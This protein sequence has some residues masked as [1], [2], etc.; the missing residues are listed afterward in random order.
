MKASESKVP[1]PRL[2]FSSLGQQEVVYDSVFGKGVSGLQLRAGFG[3]VTI[4]IPSHIRVVIVAVSSSRSIL[5][6]AF[7]SSGRRFQPF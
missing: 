5:F 4:I 6:G 1:P 2:N 3:V 7:A